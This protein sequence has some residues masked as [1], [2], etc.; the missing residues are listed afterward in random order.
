MKS[1]ISGLSG[2]N[3][4][5]SRLGLARTCIAV[6]TLLAF[7]FSP[8]NVLFHPIKGVEVLPV[9]D[10]VT[11]LSLFC[12]VG[13]DL[14]LG[15]WISGFILVW[16]IAGWWPR[17]SAVFHWWVSISF[18]LS[19]TLIEGGDA[20][21]AILTFLLVPILWLDP[22]SS[23]WKNA[24]ASGTLTNKVKSV[25]SKVFF[26]L[27]RVQMA[28]V[29]L[30]AA[31]G[32]ME[33]EEWINGTATYYWFIDESIGLASWLKP[34]VEPLLLNAFTVTSITWG[35]MILELALFGG[36]F[37]SRKHQKVLFYF[38]LAFHVAI[39]LVHGLIGFGLIMIGGL[40][41]Y[42]LP[43]DEPVRWF[44][45]KELAANEGA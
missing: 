25:F 13:G 18:V 29:Y 1:F 3:P 28:V 36:L 6:G 40:M 16:V 26:Q 12:Q 8:A 38:G 39:A 41:L 5:T 24:K 2:W 42:L 11:G 17:L 10:G 4:W 14:R 45:Q 27:I 37:M 43:L 20:L 33:V 35:A 31:V 19:A 34:L 7:I 30:H 22:R 9:C 23:H 15:M 21:A 44:W 32:K